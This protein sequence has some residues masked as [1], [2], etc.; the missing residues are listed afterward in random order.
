VTVVCP[1]FVR[2]RIADG[3]RNRPP[4]LQNSP[5]EAPSLPDAIVAKFHEAVDAG[6]EPLEV[7]DQTFD[8]IR[9]GQ[10]YVLTHPEYGVEVEKRMNAILD[11]R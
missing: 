8:A 5:D 7:A 9:S 1:G 3:E 10:L 2:T 4:E 6:I 11:Q